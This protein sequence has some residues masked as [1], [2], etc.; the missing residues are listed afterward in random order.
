MPDLLQIQVNNGSRVSMFPIHEYWL[1]IGRIP[2][3]ERAK[4]Y[5][6]Q[7]ADTVGG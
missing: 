4:A 7:S 3:Y 2:E 1:D 6:K 5:L